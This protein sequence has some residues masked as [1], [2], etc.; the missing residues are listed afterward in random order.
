MLALTESARSGH[1]AYGATTV[2]LVG[3]PP[4]LLL[5]TLVG[6]PASRWTALGWLVAVL[7]GVAAGSAIAARHGRAGASFLVAYGW[8]T[9]ARLA[10]YTIAGAWAVGAGEAAFW[11]CLVGLAVGHVTT[12]GYELAWFMRRSRGGRRS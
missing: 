2:A 6:A 1:Y 5:A 9:G 7:G 10:G 8:C 11:A 12:Q 3:A 4:L